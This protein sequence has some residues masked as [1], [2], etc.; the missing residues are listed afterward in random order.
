MEKDEKKETKKEIEE[1]YKKL[2]IDIDKAQKN[3]EY[4]TKKGTIYSNNNQNYKIS[5][6]NSTNTK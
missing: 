6:T 3:L 5:F 4:Y 1:L 2:N